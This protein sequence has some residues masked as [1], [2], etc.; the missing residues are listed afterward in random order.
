[1]TLLQDIE[2]AFGTSDLYQVL[3]I[4]KDASNEQIKKGYRKLSLK[5]HPDRVSSEKKEEYTKKFQILAQVH[6]I[7]SDEERRK[8]YDDHGII[9]NEDGLNSEADWQ[10][11]WRLLFPKVSADDITK[12]LTDYKNSEEEQEDLKAIYLR[13]K[14]DMDKISQCHIGFDE[15]A[16]R[17]MIEKMIASGEVEAFDKFVNEPQSKRDKRIRKAKKE[18]RQAKKASETKDE[19]NIG[20]LKALIQGRSQ[21]GFDSMIANLEAKYSKGASGKKRKRSDR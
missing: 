4:K 18:A 20:D 11:Y 9:M 10:Q 13:Y 1:M 3:G 5:I 19:E 7:L 21:A 17:E 16:S 2:E 6:F 8:M 12:F 15:E 14:G